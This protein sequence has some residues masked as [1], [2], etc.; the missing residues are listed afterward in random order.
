M[1]SSL[2]KFTLIYYI[3]CSKEKELKALLLNLKCNGNEMKTI[4]KIKALMFYAIN[5]QIES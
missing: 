5:F 2:L 4:Q 1:M 3:I